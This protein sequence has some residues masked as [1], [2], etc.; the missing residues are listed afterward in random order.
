MAAML[1][2]GEQIPR[3]S[4]ASRI[5]PLA[6]AS[7]GALADL[8]LDQ[9]SPPEAER[10]LYELEAERRRFIA[11]LCQLTRWPARSTL[12][13][14]LPEA[15]EVD[16]LEA[17]P[18]RWRLLTLPEDDRALRLGGLAF[19]RIFVL[20]PLYDCGKTLYGAWHRAGVDPRHVHQ[21]GERALALLRAGPLLRSGVAV[22]APDQLP[23]SWDPFPSAPRP[24]PSDR[25]ACRAWAMG[26]ALTLIYWADRL[27]AVIA[28]SQ[29]DVA[30]AVFDLVRPTH[31]AAVARLP[32]LPGLDDVVARR[33]DARQSLSRLWRNARRRSRARQSAVSPASAMERLW[34]VVAGAPAR[35][36]T[37]SLGPE[38]LP[39][40]ST[41]LLR[42]RANLDPYDGTAY[43]A[44]HLRRPPL[45]LVPSGAVPGRR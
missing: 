8:G 32:D 25:G 18:G 13:P 27:D 1:P 28:I 16:A 21:V 19:E 31:E 45:C 3:H 24:D 29:P 42:V 4:R 14:R 23:R 38:T 44:V 39:M 12:G 15:A 5:A 2:E 40:P 30:A 26:R 17:L 34:T 6:A 22:L 35:E 41:M 33:R 36:W 11:L 20:D 9:L 10:V 43:G 7:W 37:V